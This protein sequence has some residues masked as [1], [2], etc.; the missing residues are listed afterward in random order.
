MGWS[1]GLGQGLSGCGAGGGCGGAG[2]MTAAPG[3]G[4]S[5]RCSVV[6][7]LIAPRLRERSTLLR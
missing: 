5:G 6:L 1:S 2:C 7:S 3:V 4:G